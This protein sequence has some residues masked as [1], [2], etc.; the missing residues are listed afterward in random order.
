MYMLNLI[1][2]FRTENMNMNVYV[3]GFQYLNDKMLQFDL[4]LPDNI[5]YHSKITKSRWLSL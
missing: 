1:S 4:K 5:L 2:F 3:L